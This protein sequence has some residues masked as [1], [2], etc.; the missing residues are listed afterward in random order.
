MLEQAEQT[1]RRLAR[2]QELMGEL[3]I[4]L[5]VIGPS[6]DFRYL[7]AIRPYV[8]ERLAALVIPRAGASALV[9]P[10][11]QVPLYAELADRFEHVVWTESEEPIDEVARLASEHGARTIACNDDLW[12]GFLLKLQERLPGLTYRRGSAVLSRLRSI[13]DESEL[14]LLREAS[15][16]L[17]AVWEE[18]CAI[19]TLSGQTEAWV[20]RRM[21]DLMVA[22]GMPDI[23]WC[24]IG[25]GPNGASPVHSGGTRVIESGDPVTI[26]FAASYQGYYA[27]MCRTP[28]AGTPDVEVRAVYQ[29]VLDAQQAAFRAI[30]PGVPC[31]EID[32]VARGIISE[33]GYGDY[34]WHRVG[35]GIGL[36]AHE[37]PYIVEG[38]ATP[39]QPGMTFSD[40]PG[41]YLPGRFGVRI[42]DIVVVTAGGAESFNLVSRELI[43]L[44]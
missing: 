42:E 44:R 31:Q 12:A 7:T 23:I 27:D 3:E 34:F 11:L 29:A 20:D 36:A 18:F 43:C 30:R 2:T 16:R 32:R 28:V 39:L 17:D 37:D 14:G 26:D 1:A 38:N 35:H 5:L 10:A 19:T 15:R 33:R 4:D 8:S 21:R 22:H 6:A 41:V 24:D 40:E 13:K 9:L 25:S